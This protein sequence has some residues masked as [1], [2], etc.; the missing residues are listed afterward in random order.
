V[1]AQV[2]HGEQVKF[3]A[4]SG[5]GILIETKA[6]QRGWVTYWFIKELK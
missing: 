3:I 2:P 1:V 5:D 6:G 4:R